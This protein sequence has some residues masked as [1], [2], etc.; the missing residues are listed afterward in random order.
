MTAGTLR[1]EQRW[2]H[3]WISQES[4]WGIWPA[5]VEG[6][7]KLFPRE[8]YKSYV[9]HIPGGLFKSRDKSKQKTNLSIGWTGEFYFSG[10]FSLTHS[11]YQQ[12]KPGI[13]EAALISWI[14]FLRKT[15]IDW[16]WEFHEYNN[17][18]I[19][20]RERRSMWCLVCTDAFIGASV[21]MGNEI[22]ISSRLTKLTKCK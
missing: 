10:I 1:Q 19:R 12:H 21:F 20:G 14:Q 2:W 16:G 15:S 17:G 3:R 22:W 4:Q 5:G 11:L 7:L 8:G 6:I 9:C 13:P 18:R